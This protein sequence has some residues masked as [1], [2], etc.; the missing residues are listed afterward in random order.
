MK[1]GHV[2]HV[3]WAFFEG[4][5][6]EFRTFLRKAHVEGTWFKDQKIEFKDLTLRGLGLLSKKPAV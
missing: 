5:I 4:H 2:D 6:A 3:H 1:H